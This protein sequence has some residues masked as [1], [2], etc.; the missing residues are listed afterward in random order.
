MDKIKFSNGEQ[1]IKQ[2]NVFKNKKN[3]KS[4]LNVIVTNKRLICI[5]YDESGANTSNNVKEVPLKDIDGVLTTTYSKKRSIIAMVIWILL[6]LFFFKISQFFLPHFLPH[7]PRT[8]S[9]P[10]PLFN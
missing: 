7:L 2:Y 8:S 10:S 9:V 3:K 5:N 4:G 1:N 6:S